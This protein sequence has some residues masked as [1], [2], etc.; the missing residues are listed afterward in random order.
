MAPGL[1]HK[2]FGFPVL[3]REDRKELAARVNEATPANRDFVMMMT[4][5]SILASLGLIQGSTAVV[6]GAMLVAPLMGPLLGAGL[7]V[8]QGNAKLFRTALTSIGIGIAIGLSASIIVGLLNPGFEPSLEVEARGDP[9]LF[10]LGI[11][12]ASGLA[13]AYAQARPNVLGTL[14]GVAIAAALVPPLAVVGIALMS[15]RSDIAVNA[16]ILL[17]TN[18]I[19]ITL[20]AAFVFQMIGVQSVK[21]ESSGSAWPRTTMI[22]LVMGALLLVAPLLHNMLEQRLAGQ[23]RP[24][25]YPV[26]PAVREGVNEYV[27]QTDGVE[28]IALSRR[29]VEPDRAIVILLES[30]TVVPVEFSERLRATV[31]E[32]RGERTPVEIYVLLSAEESTGNE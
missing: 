24:A 22:V 14:A 10:D 27:A 3:E 25:T 2:R 9:D 30:E 32:I 13:A 26:S 18:V 17:V 23:V 5:A 19:A 11:A 12:L 20:G 15:A 8:T 16:S 4:L 31:Q 6:I 7:A 1:V 21:A 28:V 29:S